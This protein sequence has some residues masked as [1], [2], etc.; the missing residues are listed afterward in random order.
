MNVEFW[1]SQGHL[2]G[3]ALEFSLKLH[4]CQLHNQCDPFGVDM[5]RDLQSPSCFE[6]SPKLGT[7]NEVRGVGV[8]RT[9]GSESKSSASG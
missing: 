4:I 6:S 9:G 5:L 3:C 8:G 7:G 2:A 1:E